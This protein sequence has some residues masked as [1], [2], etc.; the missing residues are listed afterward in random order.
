MQNKANFKMG[1]ITISTA[2]IKAYVDKQRTMSNERHSK[3]TQSKPISNAE[4][5]SSGAKNRTLQDST[6]RTRD[7]HGLVAPRNDA[8]GRSHR[9]RI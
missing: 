7:G 2:P 9:W 6:C 8:Q 3:Q 4:K 1:N 5:Q